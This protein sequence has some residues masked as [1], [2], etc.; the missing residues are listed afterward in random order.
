MIFVQTWA[1][2][3]LGLAGAITV[4]Y[5]LRRR[6]ERLTVSALWLWRKEQERPRSALSFLWTK[7]GLLLIQMAALAALVFAL[8]APTLPQEFFGGGTFAIIIDGSASMQVHEESTTR[9]ERAITLAVEYIERRRPSRITIIQGQDAPRLLV[10]LTESRA[11]SI[12]TLRSSRPTLQNDASERSL[13]Q[14]LRSQ[15]EL[16]NYDEIIYISD[17]PSLDI[18]K[19]SVTWVPVGGPRKNLAITEFAVR[20]APEAAPGIALWTRVENFS[21]EPLEGVLKFFSEATEIFNEPVRL[22]PK[23]KRSIEMLYASNAVGRF[24]A[25]LDVSDDFVFDNVRYFVMPA[26]LKLKV[27]WVGDRNFFLERAL[28]IF[29]Q[30]EITTPANAIDADETEKYDL[31]IANGV[32]LDSLPAGRFFL[33]NSALEPLVRLGDGVVEP[34]SH[35]L[36]QAAHPIVQN[37]RLEH[38]QATNLR[39][40]ELASSVQMLI[41]SNGQPIVAAHRSRALS[42]VYLGT[43][44]RASP[45]VLTPSFPILVQNVVRWLLPESNIPPRQ[46]VS[47][48]FPAPG[49]TDLGAVNLD[50]RESEINTL[51]EERLPDHIKSMNT[52][53]VRAQ[54]PVWYYGAWG[55]L[56]LL[57]LELFFH[58]RGLFGKRRRRAMR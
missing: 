14:I 10:P 32:E 33:I 30:I 49:F 55:A 56:G 41:A 36:L 45:L 17:R 40:G 22:E 58:D 57:V 37:V 8:A 38:L 29:A 27:L 23:E 4:L 42:L 18:L 1:W 20:P 46:F 52:E 44:L 26:R 25:A 19:D 34:G 51:N 3:L 53:K 21:S 12:A 24:T 5:F 16:E 48:Q 7:I 15:S 28:S 35:Q 6:E 54:I 13:L 39:E 50:P 43:D 11:Q 31:A 2:G 47:E 9:Y